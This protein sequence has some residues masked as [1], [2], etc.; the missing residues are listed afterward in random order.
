MTISNRVQVTKLFS[1]CKL[2]KNAARQ[3]FIVEILLALLESKKVQLHEISLH[4]DSEAKEDST[5]R[6]LQSFFKDFSFDYDMV[7]F[8]LS[9][10][11]PKGKLSLCIDRTEWDFGKYQCNILVISAC[12]M[13]S[14]IPLYW[15][16]LD[17]K[18][19]NSNSQARIDLLQKC[20]HLIGKNRILR[21][22][23]DREFI[24]K[25]WI[26]YLV[27]EKIAFC[28]RVPKHHQI[29]LR[30]GFLT[31]VEELLVT[32]ELR[33]FQKVIVDGNRCNLYVKKLKNDYLFLIG[34]EFSSDLG[35][36]YRL[37]WGIEVLFQSCKQR[38]F[39]L[40]ETHFKD[41]EKIKKLLVFVFL[42][43]AICINTGILLHEKTQKI[44]VKNHGY[45]SNSFLRVGLDAWRRL[46]KNKEA[47]LLLEYLVRL[48]KI[49]CHKLKT[50][51]SS[52]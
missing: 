19:G 34:S 24:G 12:F 22:I 51:K 14:S 27:R 7:A 21:I 38:G 25:D 49:L 20:V 1:I 50:Y 44:R 6:R 52:S 32:Q 33:K 17:N 18:S 16:L 39:N 23:G 28:F 37:R 40:E 31:S 46:I 8:L 36:I 13:G 43:V 2:A 41:S 3:K 5:E 35:D 9:S 29:T 26:S 45:K 15:E 48:C 10:F 47:K 4:I 11:L 42:A 30:N